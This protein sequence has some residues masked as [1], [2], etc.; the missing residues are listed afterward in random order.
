MSILFVILIIILILIE[1]VLLHKNLLNKIALLILITEM[2]VM[3]ASRSLAVL[4]NI[5]LT[6]P[7]INEH[8]HIHCLCEHTN[9]HIRTFSLW[10]ASFSLLLYV[11]TV[12]GKLQCAHTKHV[13]APYKTHTQTEIS[14]SALELTTSFHCLF[15]VFR[16]KCRVHKS[17]HS[18]FPDRSA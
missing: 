11:C 3:D 2:K 15:T 8:T 5:H 6:D 4:C 16:N 12:G 7:S 18:Y 1:I 9:V 17:R 13:V 14:S 10:C